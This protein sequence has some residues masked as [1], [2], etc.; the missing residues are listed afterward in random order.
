[1][2]R[3]RVSYKLDSFLR[4]ERLKKKYKEEQKNAG[5]GICKRKEE[6]RDGEK[7]N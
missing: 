2:K 3:T 7:S 5:N 4:V 1:M 6:K